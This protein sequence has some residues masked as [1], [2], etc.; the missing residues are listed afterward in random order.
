MIAKAQENGGMKGH[1]PPKVLTITREFVKPGK[2]RQRPRQDRK[3]VR[4]R[5]GC[6][7]MANALFRDGFDH[8]PATL[9]FPDRLRIIRSL[10]DG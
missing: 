5:D 2:I 4:Q 3:P 9:A 10:A 8:R 7:E 6:C 1:Q